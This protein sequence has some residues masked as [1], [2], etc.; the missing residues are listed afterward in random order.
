MGKR[1]IF[2]IISLCCNGILAII[3]I[4]FFMVFKEKNKELQD[5]QE[6]HIVLM[7]DYNELYDEYMTYYLNDVIV[8]Y[9]YYYINKFEEIWNVDP[10]DLKNKDDIQES[11]SKLK[12][13]KDYCTDYCDGYNELYNEYSGYLSTGKYSEM[14]KLEK[15]K[16]LCKS[17]ITYIESYIMFLNYI[18]LHQNEIYGTYGNYTFSDVVQKKQNQWKGERESF[19]EETE[20]YQEYFKHYLLYNDVNISQLPEFLTNIIEKVHN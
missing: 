1:K 13:F 12:L 11:L 5:L 2:F 6:T 19:L 20:K 4:M 16:P 18:S 10:N 14:E 15:I 3:L 8:Q 7:N 17:T 9:E